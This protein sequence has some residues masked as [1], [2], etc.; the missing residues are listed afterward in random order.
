MYHA[1]HWTPPAFAHVGLLTDQQHQKLSK[2]NIDIDISAFRDNMGVF[3][4]TL[5]NYVALLGWSH[6]KRNDVMDL[7]EL[8]GNVRHIIL[9]CPICA[10]SF[11]VHHEIYER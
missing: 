9:S 3:P 8:I 7:Q 11:A 6:Q 1:F 2:R 10:D 4:E 5:T